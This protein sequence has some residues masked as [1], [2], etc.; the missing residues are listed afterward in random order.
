MHFGFSAFLK[1]ICLNDRPSRTE[2]RSRLAGGGGGY[3]YHKSLRRRAHRHLV[4]GVDMIEIVASL[5]EITRAPERRSVTQG[6]T[7]LQT[8]REEY[9]G[10]ITPFPAA[11]FD[12]PSGLYKVTFAPDFGIQF[13]SGSIAVHIWNTARPA[14]IPRMVYAALSLFPDLYSDLRRP[15][16]DLA[17]LSLADLRLYRLS[18][19]GS[20]ALVGPSLAQ[21]VEDLIR[22]TRRELGL[23]P[24]VER[25]GRGP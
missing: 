11:T 23:P 17:V 6:L 1:L 9:G 13:R 21:R 4:D 20:H 3:D 5:G 18:E 19:A 2:M 24:A 14:L 25:P 22:D 15:P 8:W 12:S 10:A 7:R 16:D